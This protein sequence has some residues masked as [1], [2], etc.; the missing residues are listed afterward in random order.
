MGP[1]T[2]ETGVKKPST[3]AFADHIVSPLSAVR[4]EAFP[5]IRP[6]KNCQ[7]PGSDE[8]VSGSRAVVYK[9]NCQSGRVFGPN[10]FS[11]KAND[12]QFPGLQAAP[13]AF[14]V[15]SPDQPQGCMSILVAN[16]GQECRV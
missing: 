7:P 16:M 8:G 2:E 9:T 13:S 10:A 14:N 15:F 4:I 11:S 12:E 6:D 1:G 5:K 3:P